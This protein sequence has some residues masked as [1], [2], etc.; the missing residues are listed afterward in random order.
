MLVLLV[1][2]NAVECTSQMDV[3]SSTY[4]NFFLRGDAGRA[5]TDSGISKTA[6]PLPPT[7]VGS[8]KGP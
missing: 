7:P 4:G 1:L 2:K 3:W 8:L 5:A 6:P